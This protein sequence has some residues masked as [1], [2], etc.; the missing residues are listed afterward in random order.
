MENVISAGTMPLR[1]CSRVP[2]SL[3]CSPLQPGESLQTPFLPRCC[4]HSAS[5]PLRE[6]TL[7]A[8]ATQPP[9]S[10]SPP[11]SPQA[12]WPVVFLVHGICD[13][14]LHSI[15]WESGDPD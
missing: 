11:C 3:C 9:S 14:M 12:Q 10:E 7:G 2:T 13:T 4:L 1:G 5:H 6:S 15:E 8:P